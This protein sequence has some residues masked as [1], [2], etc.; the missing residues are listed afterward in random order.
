MRTYYEV[1]EQI[2]TTDPRERGTI[3]S[4]HETFKAAMDAATKLTEQGRNVAV[5]ASEGWGK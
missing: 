4:L 2:I 5:C 3:V 1:R